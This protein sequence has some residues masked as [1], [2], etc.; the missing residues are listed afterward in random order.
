MSILRPYLSIININVS[1]GN[2]STKIVKAN[3]LKLKDIKIMSF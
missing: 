2:S 3:I 1:G